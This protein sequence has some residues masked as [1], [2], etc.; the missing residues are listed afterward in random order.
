MDG[1]GPYAGPT[2]V[3]VDSEAEIKAAIDRYKQLGYEQIKVYSSM[4]PELVPFI[5]RYSHENGLRVSGHVPAF[6]IAEEAIRQGYDEI[7]HMNFLFLNF[8]PDV[9][10]TRTPARFTA[11]AERGADLDLQSAAVRSFVDLMKTKGIVSDP[12]LIVFEGL[13]TSHPGEISPDKAEIANRFPPQVRRG[14]LTGGLPIPEGKDE[15]YLASFHRMLDFAKLLYDSGVT[16]VGGT[17]GMP[18]FDLAR[19]LELYVDAGIPAPKVLQIATLGAARVMKHDGQ[20]GSIEP[21]K[22]ADLVIIDGDPTV[23]I[24]DLRN[25][26]TVIKDGNVFDSREVQRAIGM[27][28]RLMTPGR[29]THSGTGAGTGPLGRLP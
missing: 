23:N 20:V 12:T 17:D 3:L 24:H 28:P 29:K 18:G 22:L 6:M 13:F 25:V 4:R 2:K 10:D 15:R 7:Q 21:G 19:E 26:V 16:I 8:M 9:R 27:V 5:T 1:P 11:V 14:F